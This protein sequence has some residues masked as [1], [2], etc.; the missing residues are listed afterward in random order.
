MPHSSGA[1]CSQCEKHRP[2]LSWENEV[3]HRA[4]AEQ[5]LNSG[6]PSAQIWSRGMSS[7]P[8]SFEVE[9][10]TANIWKSGDF[11]KWSGL[12]SSFKR[13][14]TWQHVPASA[15]A[16]PWYHHVGLVV[17]ASLGGACLLWSPVP[18]P[19]TGPCCPSWHQQLIP[20]IWNS[21]VDKDKQRTNGKSWEIA[22]YQTVE[23]RYTGRKKEEV[24][25][26]EYKF[27]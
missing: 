11:P 10:S 16:T 26:K 18:V 19:Y 27:P 24:K 23:K 15:T 9:G 17:A 8:Q 25:E 3:S 21:S 22:V 20:D 2:N 4:S 6:G 7:G 14:R 12:A 5:R 13:L 1:A